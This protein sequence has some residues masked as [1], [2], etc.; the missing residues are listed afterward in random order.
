M[1]TSSIQQETIKFPTLNKPWMNVNY[2]WKEADSSIESLGF[3]PICMKIIRDL[4]YY[5][6]VN[7]SPSTLLINEC[8]VLFVFSLVAI[9]LFCSSSLTMQRCPYTFRW[10]TC[11]LCVW[12]S[13]KRACT[14]SGPW[15]CWHTIIIRPTL[16]LLPTFFVS[17]KF[18]WL[19][20]KKLSPIADLW[21]KV[22][23]ALRLS[24]QVQVVRR[25]RPAL[26][27]TVQVGVGLERHSERGDPRHVA[28]L[29][30]K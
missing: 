8:K 13:L 1:Y 18:K 23:C 16:I 9:E 15:L 27:A 25:L 28:A 11:P 4:L 21:N 7:L 14:V 20:R 6:P 22:Q 5:I 12:Y 17:L 19:P 26:R 24:L 29:H 3:E 10:S 2:N 30:I